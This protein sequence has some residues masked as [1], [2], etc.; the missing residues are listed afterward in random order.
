MRP[1]DLCRR[2][3]RRPRAR[4]RAGAREPAVRRRDARRRGRGGRAHRL[5]GRG[6]RAGCDGELTAREVLDRVAELG[7]AGGWLGTW[8]LTPLRPPRS[9]KPRGWSRRRRASG[10]ALRARRDR[11]GRDPRRAPA[12][13]RWAR[14]RSSTTSGSRT[15][16]PPSRARSRRARPRGRARRAG[17]ARDSH[18][19]R[20]RARPR[21]RATLRA[22]PQA[23]AAPGAGADHEDVEPLARARLSDAAPDARVPYNRGPRHP[24]PALV[25]ARHRP[26]SR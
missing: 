5:G 11:R 23:A 14:S 3:G 4:R 24:A 16:M 2:R 20:L 17:R 21:P 8:G 9:P 18:G 10:G 25:R 22:H 26:R 6:V 13:R 19:A 12:R 15:S 1:R 7:A